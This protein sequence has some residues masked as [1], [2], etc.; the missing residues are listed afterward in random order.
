MRFAEGPATWRT[1]PASVSPVFE[2]SILYG[3]G[4]RGAK[5]LPQSKWTAEVS[6]RSLICPYRLHVPE[7]HPIRVM[8]ISATEEAASS[9]ARLERCLLD[10]RRT[11]HDRL[12]CP[13]ALLMRFHG[14]SLNGCPIRVL[15][16]N[17]AGISES[18]DSQH[19]PARHNGQS[20]FL[21][22]DQTLS[23][24]MRRSEWARRVS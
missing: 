4:P 11:M 6:N 15:H 9:H 18:R 10:D 8:T 24:G 20:K 7:H 1:L 12:V 5:K 21:P 22:H 16:G 13:D 3:V 2:T 23:R 14:R 17:G 19:H